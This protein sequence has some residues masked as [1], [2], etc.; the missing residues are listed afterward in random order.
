M[1]TKEELENISICVAAYT[2]RNDDKY[3][4]EVY[5]KI[6]CMIKTLDIHKHQEGNKFMCSKCGLDIL[7][8]HYSDYFKCEHD[9]LS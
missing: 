3:Y 6:Q 2:N 5:E 4:P 7:D 9:F 1:F 8:T